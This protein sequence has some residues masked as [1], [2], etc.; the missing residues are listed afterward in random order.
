MG[1]RTLFAALRG[2]DGRSLARALVVLLL[3]NLFAAGLDSGAVAASDVSLC[4]SSRTGGGNDAPNQ[5]RHAPDCCILGASPF[6]MALAALPP[7]VAIPALLPLGR[8]IVAIGPVAIVRHSGSATARGP[9]LD[10]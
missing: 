7:A 8:A 5:H 2:R 6:A 1:H 10:A 4:S 3:A 9:P